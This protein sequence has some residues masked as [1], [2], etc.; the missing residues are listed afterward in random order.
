MDPEIQVAIRSQILVNCDLGYCALVP[1]AMVGT[2]RATCLAYSAPHRCLRLSTNEQAGDATTR[3]N[4]ASNRE[5]Q[6]RDGSIRAC[7]RPNRYSI[8]HESNNAGSPETSPASAR[9]LFELPRSRL[10][11]P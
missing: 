7:A 3:A 11:V 5:C 1:G 6:C 10:P 4:P 9:L 2:A 8:G